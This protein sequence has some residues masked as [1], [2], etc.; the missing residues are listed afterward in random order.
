[1]KEKNVTFFRGNSYIS[2]E[3]AFSVNSYYNYV[4]SFTVFTSTIKLSKFLSF[5]KAFMQVGWLAS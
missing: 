2:L 1:L 3:S 5:Q 4:L